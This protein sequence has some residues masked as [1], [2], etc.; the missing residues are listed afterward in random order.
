M[1]KK[2]FLNHNNITSQPIITQSKIKTSIILINIIRNYWIKDVR[3]RLI[4]ENTNEIV[5]IV[6]VNDRP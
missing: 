2:E 4:N 5:W 3:E 6:I 1:L